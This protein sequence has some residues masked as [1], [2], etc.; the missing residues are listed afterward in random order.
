MK[1]RWIVLPTFTVTQNTAVQDSVCVFV[2]V[3]VLIQLVLVLFPK[4]VASRKEFPA[5][6]LVHFPNV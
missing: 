3:C 1:K 4:T 2:C 5:A 6:F